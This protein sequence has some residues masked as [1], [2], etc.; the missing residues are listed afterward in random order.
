MEMCVS[1]AFITVVKGC[2]SLSVIKSLSN[3]VH[4][5]EEY[6]KGKMVCLAV[7]KRIH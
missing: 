3:V 7:W 5:C 6:S 4:L 1:R 2:L